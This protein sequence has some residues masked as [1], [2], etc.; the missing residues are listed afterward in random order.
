MILLKNC[1]LINM[2]G[3]YEENY[4]ILIDGKTIKKIEK[5]INTNDYKDAKIIDVDGKLVTPGLIESHCH[6][7]IYE[8]AVPEGIDGNETTNP[9]LPGLRAIDAID[10]LDSAYDVAIKHGITTVVTG[11]GSAN[12]MG[13]TFC[14]MKTAGKSLDRNII[15]EEA[16]FKMALGENPKT[17]YGGKGIA[18]K[19][20]M[21]SAA[22]MREALFKAKKYHEDYNAY[23]NGEKE[24]YKYDLHMHSLMRAF[25]GMRVKIHAHQADDIMTGIRISEEF[26]LNY[27]IDHCTGGSDIVDELVDHNVDCIIGP[28]AGGKGKYELKNKGF[29]LGKLLQERN[30]D[31]AITT[32]HPV[33]PI[34]GL[35]MQLAMYV[36]NGVTEENALKAVTINAARV[37][38]IDKYVGSIEEGKDADIVIWEIGPLKTMSKTDMV[39]VNGEVVYEGEEGEY[40]VDYKK[41]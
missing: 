32:D 40:D 11:P 35:L 4:D 12:V 6:M 21:M 26:G 36:K 1:N 25:D 5:N 37:T 20:R 13:G 8:T 22:L 34:E 10:P 30:I 27:T 17:F 9:V 15:K 29:K 41:Y 24:S 14:A 39:I 3:I 33:I 2:A 18:P 31:F 16:T 28:S 7:G 23:L 19:T 38:D